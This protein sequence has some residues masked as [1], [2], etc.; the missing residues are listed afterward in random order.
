MSHTVRVG[1][2]GGGWPGKAQARGYAA[3]TGFKIM[4]IA[5]LIPERR[6]AMMDE[7]HIPAEFAEATELIEKGDVDAV[8]ICLPNHLHAPTAI[9]ALKAGKHVLCEY[10]PTTSVKEAKA[11]ERAAAQAQKVV[12]YAAPRR[13]GACEQAAEQ[14]I[15]KGY[16]GGVYHARAAWMRTR[17]VPVGTGWFTDK[18]RSGGGALVDIGL[19]MLDLAWRLLG[20]PR[21]VAAFGMT[22]RRFLP[23][24]PGQGTP[25][26][27]EDAAFAMLRFEAGKSLELA[28]SWAINQPPSQQGT[29]CRIYGETGAVDV[30]TPAGAVMHRGFD[31]AGQSKE[32]PLK[33]PKT[34][35]YAAI[36]RHFHDCI[37]GKTTPQAGTK[38]GVVLMQM[39]EAIYK[40]AEKGIGVRL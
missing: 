21:P 6:K 32:T 17:A 10:P 27:V 15:V 16:A 33:L 26:D 34:I 29:L 7:F 8:S 5:D 37:S 3:T 9:A 36:A 13:F 1:I 19:H 14:T 11:I 23:T 12:L 39:V 24:D 35:G 20:Q 22:H 30:Y 25:A 4:A 28:A 31:A 18:S 38:E 40:S 2:I